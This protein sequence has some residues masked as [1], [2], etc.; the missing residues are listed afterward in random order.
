MAYKRNVEIF[1]EAYEKKDA[2][3]VVSYVAR[4]GRLA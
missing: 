1:E 4:D 2:K 3:S